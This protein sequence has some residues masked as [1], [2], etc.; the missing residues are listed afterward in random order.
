ML[1]CLILS[2]AQQ[3][4]SRQGHGGW[5][6]AN[7]DHRYPITQPG[8]AACHWHMARGRWASWWVAGPSCGRTRGHRAQPVLAGRHAPSSL[9]FHSRASLLSFRRLRTDCI[10]LWLLID[11]ALPR[12]AH[13]LPK[14]TAGRGKGLD[15]QW[16]SVPQIGKVNRTIIS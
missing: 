12:L 13:S 15:S 16:R 7:C 10:W 5:R 6:R 9:R 8:G 3:A 2:L 11:P 4:R 1:G 14:P